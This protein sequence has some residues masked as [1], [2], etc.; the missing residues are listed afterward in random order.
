MTTDSVPAGADPRRLLADTRRLAHRVRL[1][2]R[3]TWFPLLVL[4]AVTFVAIPVE[5]Y[6]PRDVHCQAIQDGTTCTFWLDGAVVYWPL[7]LLLA[8]VA[9][10]YCYVRVARARGLNTRVLPYVLT[11]IVLAALFTAVGLTLHFLV[12]PPFDLSAI[13]IRLIRLLEPAGAIGLALL[14][15]ARLERHLALL[16]FTLGYLVVV[17]VP[18]DFGWGTHWGPVWGFAPPLVISGGVL[19]LGGLGFAL[20]Q[21]RGRSQ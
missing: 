3:V 18:I 1:A 17:L 10:A 13:V 2:Q 6:G 19:L 21:R 20:A 11:G 9:I 15:L 4:A 7:A 8:Y 14:V 12:K 5:R 16:L